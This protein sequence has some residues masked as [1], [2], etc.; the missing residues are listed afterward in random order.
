MGDSHLA[1][2][3]VSFEPLCTTVK[4]LSPSTLPRARRVGGWLGSSRSVPKAGDPSSV[5]SPRS[6]N[7]GK[8]WKET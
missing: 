4:L 5:E 1:V 2:S 7:L 3:G 8:K 6:L